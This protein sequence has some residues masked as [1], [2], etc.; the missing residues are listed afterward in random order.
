[1]E[2]WGNGSR[3]SS[4]LVVVEAIERITYYIP[5][6]T[7]Q[8]N[9]PT[10]IDDGIATITYSLHVFEKNQVI[11]LFDDKGIGGIAEAVKVVASSQIALNFKFHI[12]TSTFALY[13]HK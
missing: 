3:P 8:D 10:F 1:M 2:G 4:L 9:T 12:T 5:T 7:L 11:Q 6:A 13:N